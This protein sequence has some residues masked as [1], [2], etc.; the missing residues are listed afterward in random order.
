[1]QNA[2]AG[3]SVY[4]FLISWEKLRRISENVCNLIFREIKGCQNVQP[5]VW[6]DLLK[7]QYGWL[8]HQ[9]NGKYMNWGNIKVSWVSLHVFPPFLQR[10]TTS[11]LLGPL[12]GTVDNFKLQ[13]FLLSKGVNLKRIFSHGRTFWKGYV[14]RN[15]YET[16]KIVPLFR[17]YGK[18]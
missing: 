1:M 6:S 4:Y 10:A 12:L 13:N 5:K 7:V 11:E 14:Q 3:L 2:Q 18:V 8:R 9:G 17:N 16:T 15:K